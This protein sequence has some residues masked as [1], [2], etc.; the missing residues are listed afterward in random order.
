MKRLCLLLTVLAAFAFTAMAQDASPSSSSSG[1]T[2]TKSSKSK[3]GDHAGMAMDHQDSMGK[4]S[5]KGSTL[6]GCLSS[7]ANSE[8]MYT[9][10]NAK[11]KK[12]VEV[13][14]ADKVKEHAG[15]Q[16]SLTG[17]WSTAAE[18]GEK[19]EATEKKGERHFEV[20]SVKHIAATCSEAPGGG[21]TGSKMKM[22]KGEKSNSKTSSSATPPPAR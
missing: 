5:G 4:S 10:S 6:T 9:L 13:G 21:T 1:Q 11:N 12:G 19:A 2:T 15:H 22:K 7:S 16:V 14:P 3:S 20:D 8:G 18:A 17:K